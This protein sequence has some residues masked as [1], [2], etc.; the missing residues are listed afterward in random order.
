MQVCGVRA[1]LHINNHH[2]V[3]HAT[4]NRLIPN[5]TKSDSLAILTYLHLV[6]LLN[7]PVNSSFGHLYNALAIFW[8]AAAVLQKHFLNAKRRDRS[9]QNVDRLCIKRI[10]LMFGTQE[11]ISTPIA[12]YL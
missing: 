7:E 12:L 1:F 5:I 2:T 4:T 3:L 9:D 11:S 10:S 8:V 6:F